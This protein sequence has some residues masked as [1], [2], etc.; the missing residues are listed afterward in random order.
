ME[1]FKYII[2]TYLDKYEKYADGKIIFECDYGE[3][4]FVKNVKQPN[5]IILYEIF[6]QNKYRQQGLCKEI[7]KYLIDKGSYKFNYLCIISVLSDILYNYLKRF[8]Y[9]GKQ[10]S[11]ENDGFIYSL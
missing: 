3:L 4:I 2:D 5:T 7:I 10:F 11:I 8:D 6:I 1:Q 9:K